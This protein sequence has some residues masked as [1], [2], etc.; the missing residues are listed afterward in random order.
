VDWV[1]DWESLESS[2][3]LALK[4][5]E[6]IPYG[7]RRSY[8]D[9]AN[10]GS[11][12]DLGRIMGANP[13]PIVAPCHRVTRG[14]EVPTTFVGGPERRHWLEAHETAACDTSR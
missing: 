12:R 14:V 7:G 2:A 4:S 5:T 8:V 13:I 3:A 9:L 10:S 1:V 11:V 6:S